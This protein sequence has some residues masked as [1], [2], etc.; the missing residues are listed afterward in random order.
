MKKIL[1]IEDEEPVRMN[2]VELLE[3]EG[4]D[5]LEAENGRIGLRL[6]QTESPDLIISDANMPELD[7]YGVLSALRQNPKTVAI[8]FIFLTARA[9]KV[10]MRQ[11]MRLGADDYL[12]KPFTLNELMHAVSSRLERHEAIQQTL[13]T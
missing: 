7:G 6:A 1:V 5:V 3:L 13:N 11:G 8:P 10:D 12:T 9:E 4:F 2:I